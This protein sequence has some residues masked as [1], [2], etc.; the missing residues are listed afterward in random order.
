MGLIV[1]ESEL[2]EELGCSRPRITA[3]I[4]DGLPVEPDGRINLEHACRWI[5]W[6]MTDESRIRWNATELLG[7]L[8]R[9]RERGEPDDDFGE[10]PE[11]RASA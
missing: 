7:F 9:A 8:E 3:L 2:A 4:A 1:K 6:N 10:D 5:V 11:A